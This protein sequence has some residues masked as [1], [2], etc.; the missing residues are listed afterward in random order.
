MVLHLFMNLNVLQYSCLK[1]KKKL[2][3]GEAVILMYYNIP[4]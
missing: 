2:N 3:W 4:V 1:G